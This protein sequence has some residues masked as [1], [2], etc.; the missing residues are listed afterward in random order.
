MLEPLPLLEQIFCGAPGRIRTCD[1]LANPVY[2]TGAVDHWATG[3]NEK[4]RNVSRRTMPDSNRRPP[5]LS[6]GAH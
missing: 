2:K 6:S 5:E 3:A 4:L 1:A